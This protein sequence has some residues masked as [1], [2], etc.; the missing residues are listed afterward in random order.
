[1]KDTKQSIFSWGPN[2]PP[3][4]V[5]PFHILR[6]QAVE[7]NNFRIQVICLGYVAESGIK[8]FWVL[9]Q[10]L[11]YFPVLPFNHQGLSMIK[12]TAPFPAKLWR[13]G[14]LKMKLLSRTQRTVL[15]QGSLQ[16][17]TRH[18]DKTYITLNKGISWAVLHNSRNQQPHQSLLLKR[19]DWEC[20]AAVPWWSGKPHSRQTHRKALLAFIKTHPSPLLQ[21]G[22]VRV[23][24]PNWGLQQP[25]KPHWALHF[26]L[27][28]TETILTSGIR[29]HNKSPK[30]MWWLQ[31]WVVILLVVP[32][33]SDALLGP[34][35]ENL[36]FWTFWSTHFANLALFFSFLKRTQAGFVY[37]HQKLW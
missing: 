22:W 8:V 33:H 4:V 15:T 27:R 20:Q 30:Q 18:G 10:P 1:M 2:Q 13:Q 32:P 26:T 36:V 6:V 25:N 14:V 5:T 11:N 3:W 9:A 16:W 21:L 24:L 17:F 35:S 19:G 23:K 12:V 7:G 28:S 34:S 31:T 29:S 37:H